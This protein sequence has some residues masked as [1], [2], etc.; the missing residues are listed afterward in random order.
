M[1]KIPTIPQYPTDIA[2]N[3]IRC[4]I[5]RSSTVVKIDGKEYCGRV[6]FPSLKRKIE[7]SGMELEDVREVIV[8]LNKDDAIPQARYTELIIKTTN[9]TEEF[10]NVEEVEKLDGDDCYKLTARKL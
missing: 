1:N 7:L 4:V 10:F 5:A 9:D 3:R 2:R 8:A 6:G